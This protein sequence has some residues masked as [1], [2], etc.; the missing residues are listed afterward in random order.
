M[1]IFK[2]WQPKP[3]RRFLVKNHRI[4]TSKSCVKM[5]IPELVSHPVNHF[6]PLNCNRNQNLQTIFSHW[7]ETHKN[8]LNI[9]PVVLSLAQLR[10]S[11]FWFAIKTEDLEYHGFISYLSVLWAFG[12]CMVCSIADFVIAVLDIVILY[13]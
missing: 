12:L 13:C 6:Q 1:F 4:W 5:H 11:L 10:P 9:D 2:F 8:Q 7:V 3:Q